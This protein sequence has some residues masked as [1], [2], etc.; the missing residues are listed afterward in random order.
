MKKT[1]NGIAGLRSKA[2]FLWLL[3][4]AAPA[5][6]QEAASEISAGDTAWILVATAFVILM[7]APGLALFYGG[8]V[9]QRNVLSTLM[10]SFFAL[11]FISVQWVVIGYSLAFGEGVGGVFGGFN[12][13]FFAGVGQEASGTIPH[14]LFAMF[15]GAFAVIT[16]ALITGAIVERLTFK[17]YLLF[18]LLWTTIVYDPLCYWVW[19]GGWIGEMGALDFAGGTVVHISS[20]ISALVACLIIGKRTGF[21]RRVLPPHSVPFVLLGTSLLWFGWFGF[22][23]GSA[24][25]ADGLAAQAFATTHIAAATAGMTWAFMEWLMDGKPTVLGAATGVVAGLVGITPAAGFVTVSSALA[26][27][28]GAGIF[29]YIGV[30]KLK[31]LFGYDDSLD[32]VGVHGIGGT[33]GALATGIFATTSV[34]AAGADGLLYGNPGQMIPQIVSVVATWALAGVGTAVILGVIKMVVP[35]RVNV[36][37]ESQGCDL[38]LHGETAY[39]FLSP[40]MSSME[41]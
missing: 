29:C 35:L 41:K 10:H 15:Q 26:I 12:H 39:N 9:N 40:G 4:L 36:E 23:A 21:P 1:M 27:G 19:G 28:L 6:A 32:V 13:I 22:N 11:C 34:N 33:W 38:A 30:Y 16:F 24:L 17:A 37:D 8:L 3:L 7:T 18:G 2:V 14:I 5:F 31:P 20:G 25:A